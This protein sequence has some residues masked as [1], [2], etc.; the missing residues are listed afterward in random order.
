MYFEKKCNIVE[1][2][3]SQKLVKEKLQF[4]VVNLIKDGTKIK[5]L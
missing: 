3:K 1:V 5:N 4:A 2:M